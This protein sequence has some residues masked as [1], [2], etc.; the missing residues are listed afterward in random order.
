MEK[1]IFDAFNDLFEA[2]LSNEFSRETSFDRAKEQ[3]TKQYNGL[4]GYGTYE[5]FKVIR[6]R[7]MKR[8]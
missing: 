1:R 4:S 3:F 2:N 8:S 7:K 6:S 5:S